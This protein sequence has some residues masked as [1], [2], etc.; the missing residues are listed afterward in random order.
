[1]RPHNQGNWKQ[2]MAA[3]GI[4]QQGGVSPAAHGRATLTSFWA[5][6]LGTIGVVYG[7]IGTSPFYALKES[8]APPPDMRVRAPSPARWCSAWSP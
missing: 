1:V 4:S 6:T 8:L 3:T 2:Y 7:D 5:L